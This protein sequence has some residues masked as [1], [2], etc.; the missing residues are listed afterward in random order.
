MRTPDCLMCVLP[1]SF[2]TGWPIVTKVF[3]N[4]LAFQLNLTWSF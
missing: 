2:Q 4:L 3:T 1:S